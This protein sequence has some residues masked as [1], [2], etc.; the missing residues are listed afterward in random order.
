MGV[1]RVGAHDDGRHFHSLGAHPTMGATL[2]FDNLAS[3]EKGKGGEKKGRRREQERKEG[4]L[5]NYLNLGL[6]L[7]LIL[8]SGLLPALYYPSLSPSHCLRV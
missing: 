5:K 4:D 1:S 8:T 6:S 3:K 2:Y 7:L